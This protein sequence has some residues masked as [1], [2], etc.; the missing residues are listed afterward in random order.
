MAA[1]GIRTGNFACGMGPQCRLGTAGQNKHDPVRQPEGG[2]SV[3]TGN[4]RGDEVSPYGVSAAAMQ[5]NCQVLSGGSG[6]PGAS[7]AGGGGGSLGNVGGLAGCLANAAFRKSASSGGACRLNAMQKLYGARRG[8]RGMIGPAVRGV[9]GD[10]DCGTNPYMAGEARATDGVGWT[11]SGNTGENDDELSKKKERTNKRVAE[12]VLSGLA[13]QLEDK[14]DS[15][16]L[17][18]LGELVAG[19]DV[20]DDA[21]GRVADALT[22]TSRKEREFRTV[23]VDCDGVSDDGKSVTLGYTK[24]RGSMERQCYLC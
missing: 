11:D 23:C 20:S 13:D 19:H 2:R 7:A 6:S 12:A 14:E 8:G 22:R 21:W 18:S 10:T 15:S 9:Y 16:G 3:K 24:G 4:D 1:R 17:R 5:G